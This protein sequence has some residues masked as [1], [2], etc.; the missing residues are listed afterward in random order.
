V[1]EL[2]RV[3]LEHHPGLV[4]LGRW[5]MYIGVAVSAFIS[6]LSLLPHINSSMPARSQL[7]A[8]WVAGGRGVT[9]GLV[10]FL[11]LMMFALGRYPVHLSRNVTLN[12]VLFTVVFLLDS[13][14]AILRTIFDRRMNPWVAATVSAVEVGCFVLWFLRL[15]AEGENRQANWIHFGPEYEKRML[16]RLDALNQLVGKRVPV[17]Q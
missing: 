7:L 11:I 5:G 9:F 2:C 16:Q 1:R 12:A 14:A 15:S 4:T 10:I 13:L 3:V 17:K 6:F 8:Y